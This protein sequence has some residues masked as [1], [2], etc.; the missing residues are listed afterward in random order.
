MDPRYKWSTYY[1][2]Q[3]GGGCGG[4][5]DGYMDAPPYAQHMP[6]SSYKQPYKAYNYSSYGNHNNNVGIGGAANYYKHPQPPWRAHWLHRA[7]EQ[8]A[9]PA[10]APER[11]KSSNNTDVVTLIVDNNNLKRMIVLHVNLLQEQ[12]DKLEKKNQLLDEKNLRIETLLAQ[13]QELLQQI[14]MLGQT[15]EELRNQRRRSSKRSANEDEAPKAKLPCF[16]ETQTQT[17]AEQQQVLLEQLQVQQQ[18]V[19]VQQDVLVMEPMHHCHTPPQAHVAAAAAQPPPLPRKQPNVIVTSVTELPPTTPALGHIKARGFNGGKKI[20]TIILH[21]VHQESSSLQL[22]EEQEKQEHEEQDEETEETELQIDEEQQEHEGVFLEEEEQLHDEHIYHDGMVGMTETIIGAEE[23]LITEEAEQQVLATDDGINNGHTLVVGHYV[24]IEKLRRLGIKP[25]QLRL[26]DSNQSPNQPQQQQ[27]LQ[28]NAAED[29]VVNA[30]L[31]AQSQSEILMPTVVDSTMDVSQKLKPSKKGPRTF[32]RTRV[33]QQQVIRKLPTLEN[34]TLGNEIV[35]NYKGMLAKPALQ[36]QEQERLRHEAEQLEVQL[37]QEEEEEKREQQ[38]KQREK[39]REGDQLEQEKINQHELELQK[40]EQE[41]KVEEAALRQRQE[42]EPERLRHA[43]KPFEMEVKPE[44]EEEREQQQRQLEQKK[45]KLEKEQERERE[46]QQQ[47]LLQEQ[48]E[49]E[50]QREQEQLAQEKVQKLAVEAEALRQRQALERQEELNKKERAQRNLQ[51]VVRAEQKKRIQ[52]KK[53]KQLIEQKKREREQKKKIELQKIRERNRERQE[54]LNEQHQKMDSTLISEVQTDVKKQAEQ[55]SDKKQEQKADKEEEE[56]EEPNVDEETI[57]RRLH[58]HLQKQ[59]ER[60]QTQYKSMMAQHP[61]LER[62]KRSPMDINMGSNY[63]LIYPPLP[64]PTTTIGGSSTAMTPAPT[65]PP[66]NAATSTSTSPRLRGLKNQTSTTTTIA[67][68]PAAATTIIETPTTPESSGKRKRP[69]ASNNN[70]NNNSN[71]NNN[72]KT[73]SN[74]SSTSRLRK[75]LQPYT[76]RSWEDQ[77]F[78]CDNEFFLEEADELLADN[79]SLEIPKWKMI[80]LRRSSDDKEIEPMSNDAFE[81]RHDKYV[82]EEIERKKRDA[83]YNQE[84]N[85]I[86]ALRQRHNQDEVLV[87]LPP[88]PTST[89]YPLPEDIEI[90]Q[91]VSEVP[92]Q[93]FGENMMYPRLQREHFILPW[94]S[95]A[96]TATTATVATLAN[97][98]LP[99]SKKEARHQ[100]LNSS[101]VFLKRRKRQQ[102]R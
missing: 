6:R 92:V 8:P 56:E 85:K 83:R 48:E 11:A 89:F 43:V 96:A 47:Q 49:L 5:N 66:T 62:L 31:Q 36:E 4:G 14:A 71:N 98:R 12:A 58:E 97:K 80:S 21:R 2:Q 82:R 101:Y 70:N 34:S 26:F 57:V 52:E 84:Q 76:T 50:K 86:E 94:L 77:E 59:H 64:Q 1:Q 15:V 53:R 37:K 81:H 39:Q 25:Q 87:P 24:D 75:S 45:W 23:E 13:K 69:L 19:Q 102:R 73:I 42:L 35:A 61:P 46:R 16:V 3:R 60:L 22:Q 28:S 40:Q 72:N 18:Q 51:E 17:E 100:E 99:T 65:P 33:N 9:P 90:I 10:Q 74:R 78:H 93:A 32:A 29:E 44:E 41:A 38:Q 7:A 79:P 67:A 88:L 55:Q 95:T 91:F 68:T 63:S 54:L 27:Q 30:L 20:S